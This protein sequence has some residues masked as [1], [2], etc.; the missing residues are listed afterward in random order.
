MCSIRTSKSR[1]KKCFLQ[2]RKSRHRTNIIFLS[3][4]NIIDICN[5][6]RVAQSV[7]RLTTGWTV[8]GS[9]PGGGEVFRTCPDRPWGPP[10][11]L[12][13]GYRV[14]PGGKEWPG[15][16][17]DPSHLLVPWS[18]KGRTIPPLPLRA[19]RPVQSLSACT[20]MTFTFTFTLLAVPHDAINNIYFPAIIILFKKQAKCYIVAH[21]NKYVHRLQ[22]GQ[23]PMQTLG[24]DKG[25]NGGHSKVRYLLLQLFLVGTLT[26]M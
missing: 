4:L 22:G 12:C 2:S 16:D 13:N 17:A 8:R 3:K 24:V 14:F 10:S 26:G 25:Q 15:R 23:V 19:V 9:N 20:R 1:P 5:V 7:Q 18:R 6:D 11:L 21:D